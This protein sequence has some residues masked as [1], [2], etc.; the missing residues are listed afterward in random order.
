MR[1]VVNPKVEPLIVPDRFREFVQFEDYIGCN[2]PSQDWYV[3]GAGNGSAAI[4]D[5][6]GGQLRV[7]CTTN[8]ST[9][10]MVQGAGDNISLS[11][12]AYVEFY[13]KLVPGTGGASRIGLTAGQVSDWICWT[14]WQNQANVRMETR[15]YGGDNPI[16]DS[17]IA[18]STNFHRYGFEI[19]DGSVR[20]YLDGVYVNK[21]DTAIS[22][23]NM[24]LLIL[25]ERG[26][27]TTDT[28]VDYTYVLGGRG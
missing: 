24:G 14:Q 25:S 16:V 10:S 11:L 9:I 13:A 3:Y 17:G 8:G 12:G 4:I 19:G 1:P 15:I 27:T 18:K 21:I 28:I 7:R 2:Y 5:G 23:Q 6:Q 22:I 26:T 20:F